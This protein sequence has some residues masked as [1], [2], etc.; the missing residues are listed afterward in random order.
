M[1]AVSHTAPAI[2]GER[3]HRSYFLIRLF[4]T[5]EVDRQSFEMD[6]QAAGGEMS[7]S[8]A[9][10]LL[11]IRLPDGSLRCKVMRRRAELYCR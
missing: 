1:I 11:H 4:C 9:V 2:R 5:A 6:Q 10:Q 3:L 8:A 7:R